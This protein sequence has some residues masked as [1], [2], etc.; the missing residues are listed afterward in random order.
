MRCAYN[1]QDGLNGGEFGFGRMARFESFDALGRGT[2]TAAASFT[3]GADV[4]YDTSLIA[5]PKLAMEFSALLIGA[6][7][8]YGYYLQDGNASGVIILEGGLNI[9]SR[10]FVYAGYNFVKRSVEAPVIAEGLR[11]S[12]G[13][14]YPF[15]MRRVAPPKRPDHL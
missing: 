4:A 7:V 1:H 3:F 15:G 14:N 12:A 9:F 10:V 5:A 6:R 13:F 11:F 8:G 2:T